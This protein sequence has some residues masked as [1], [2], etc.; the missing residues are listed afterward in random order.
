MEVLLHKYNL[1]SEILTIHLKYGITYTRFPL[2][3]SDKQFLLYL[4]INH[5]EPT[6]EAMLIDFVD[7]CP[8][9]YQTLSQFVQVRNE[10]LKLDYPLNSLVGKPCITVFSLEN[11]DT[12]MGEMAQGR[13]MLIEYFREAKVDIERCTPL[14]AQAEEQRKPNLV[15]LIS[16][17][18][19]PK[20]KLIVKVLFEARSKIL[21]G[22]W[23]DDY[24]EFI[25]V[26]STLQ[27]ALEVTKNLNSNDKSLLML[28]LIRGLPVGNLETLKEE[29]NNLEGE[30]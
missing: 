30:Q 23:S 20:L 4:L 17:I 21:S 27:T 16:V 3:Q 2:K 26:S 25:R 15:E 7:G 28:E 11:F 5:E 9:F 13:T 29:V 14:L 1:L 22:Y 10:L 12:L 8:F 18:K 6:H 24:S 19:S